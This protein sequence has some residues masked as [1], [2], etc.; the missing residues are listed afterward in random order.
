[1]ATEAFFE[2]PEQLQ[3]LLPDLYLKLKRFYG[4]DPNAD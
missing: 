2:R 1:V 3:Q 4:F